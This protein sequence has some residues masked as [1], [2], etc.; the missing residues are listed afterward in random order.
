M[1]LS[2]VIGLEIHVQLKTK[3]KMFCGCAA[4]T[5]RELE[6]NVNV[7]PICLG[8]P[9]TLPVPNEQA[10]RWAI[11]LGL[12]L[13]GTIAS[14]SK[15]DRKNYFYPDL[16]KAYQISQFDLPI[17]SD[18]R[19]SVLVP[20]EGEVT[21]GIERMHLEEDAA[22]NIHGDDG[23]TYV[24][25]NRGGTPLCEIVTKP[26]FISPAQAKIFL[27]ELRTLVRAL[28]ISDGD[29][30]KGQMRCDVNISLRE[31]DEDGNPTTPHLNPKTE[32]KNIN[33]FRAVERAIQF[34]IRR[35]KQL[36]EMHTPPAITT[37]RG[38]NDE[39]Q[40]TDEQRSKE[41]SADY[42]Y[43]PEPDI[44]PMHLTAMA[45]EMK[46][47]MPEL[48]WNKRKRLMEEYGFKLEDASLMVEDPVL[49]DFSEQA[50]SE[51]GAW[52]LAL[53][54]VS[55]E[56]MPEKRKKMTQIFT[57]W[58][59]NKLPGILTE[60][61]ISHRTMKITPE[62]FA[63]FI[64]LMAEGR[65]TGQSGLKV[66]ERMLD[67]GS[68]PSH[69]MEDLGASR[70]DDVTALAQIIDVVITANPKEVARLKAGEEKLM[71]FLVGQVMRETRGNADPALTA[72]LISEKLK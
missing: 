17:M 34:E 20:G 41:D 3:T 5:L 40:C 25:F 36:W 12:S 69:A 42:R 37:T 32:I 51:L 14:V 2:P 18:G 72:K 7:C 9:G 8:H 49:A 53:P 4:N 59:L 1:N 66:L 70:M 64:I 11:L 65:L 55:P 28:D 30:E 62:N 50:L 58:L 24:D 27:Q 13:G 45:E 15:F 38:W 26:H 48:P 39:K 35:Q 67:D 46:E 57:S 68:D 54:D 33:S 43:F 63:E 44:P 19:L 21:I 22:K 16:P 10:I 60:R 23:K 56:D 31:M 71:Q 61:K 52:I 6:P 47:T 29:M